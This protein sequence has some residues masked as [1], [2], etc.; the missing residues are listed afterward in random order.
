M[1]RRPSA[2]RSARRGSTLVEFSFVAFTLMLMIFAG[3]EFDRMMLL[4]NTLTEAAREGARYAIC[5]GS[6]RPDDGT[7]NGASGPGTSNTDTQIKNLVK[8]YASAGIL[9]TANLTVT[10]SYSNS[11]NAHGNPVQVTVSYPYD[12]FTVLPLNVTFRATSKGII[13]F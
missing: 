4:Y 12:P 5:H 10:V 11:S 1:I 7:V 6:Q 9:N 8:R 3:I 13:T 2:R